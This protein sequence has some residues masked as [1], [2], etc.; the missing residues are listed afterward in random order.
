[1]DGGAPEVSV[2]VR[3]G[4]GEGLV[5][6]LL[7]PSIKLRIGRCELPGG[8]VL[9]PIADHRPGADEV[10][11]QVRRL[12]VTTQGPKRVIGGLPAA[13]MKAQGKAFRL[14]PAGDAQRIKKRG[15]LTGENG[16][17]VK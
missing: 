15:K 11:L 9:R 12:P 13:V 14:D 7:Q 16:H 8:K 10:D 4:D 17:D 6:A 5:E 2:L 3:T 1:M